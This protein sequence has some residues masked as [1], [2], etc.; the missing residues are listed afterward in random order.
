MTHF[1]TNFSYLKDDVIR[2]DYVQNFGHKTFIEMH[3]TT[4]KTNKIIY[5]QK[6]FS[7]YLIVA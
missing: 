7:V 2:K 4:K 3:F 6:I 5:V 1:Q